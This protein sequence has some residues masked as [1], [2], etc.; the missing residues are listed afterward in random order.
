MKWYWREYGELNESDYFIHSWNHALATGEPITR[1]QWAELVQRAEQLSREDYQQ[2]LQWRRNNPKPEGKRRKKL[3]G[4][5]AR[6][7]IRD[8]LGG[9][10]Q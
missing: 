7:F 6:A 2:K 9:R 8:L 1:Q 4:R 10:I 5:S 3:E